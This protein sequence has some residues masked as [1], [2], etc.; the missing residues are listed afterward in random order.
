MTSAIDFD[1]VVKSSSSSDNNNGNIGAAF[2]PENPEQIIEAPVAPIDGNIF[3]KG[4]Y[5][6]QLAR[7]YKDKKLQSLRPWKVFLDREEFSIPG[8]LEAL[9]R[10]PDNITYFNSNYIFLV[11]LMSIYILITNLFFMVG[12][13]LCVATYYWVKMKQQAG[14]PIK[15][16]SQEL[17]ATQSYFALFL[18]SLFTFYATD[19][20]STVFWLVTCAGIVV[21]GHASTRK[22]IQAANSNLNPAFSFA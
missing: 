9:T 8:K 21:L 12:M 5:Y 13:S 11:S 20:S 14:E 7:Y 17:T 10:I 4:A 19:G 15:I 1:P 22:P 2:D 3:Q 18:L 16:G 6:F